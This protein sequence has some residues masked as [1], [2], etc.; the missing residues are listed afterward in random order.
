MFFGMLN[1]MEY[2]KSDYS[3]YVNDK[4]QDGCQ[5]KFFF[6]LLRYTHKISDLAV[7]AALHHPLIFFI[8]FSII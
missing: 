4:I 7:S 5:K 2:S 6:K 3:E 1:A 8:A